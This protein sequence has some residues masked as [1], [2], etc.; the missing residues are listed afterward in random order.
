MPTPAPAPALL[1]VDWGTTAL[2]GAL[3]AADGRP[4]ASHAAPRGLLSVPPGGW[5][6]AFEAE[7]G[8]WRRA[9]P[10]LPC[11]MAGMVGSR[12]GWAEAAYCPCPAGLDDLARQLLWVLPGEVAIVPG[13]S[14]ESG[15]VPDV[16]RG[17][18]TQVFGAL[19]S[20]A[21]AGGDHCL[22]LPG[23]H[24]KWV[25]VQGGRIT[26]FST[27]MTG[28]CYAL[29]RQQSILARML[30]ADDGD[31]VAE[32]FDAGITQA[33][34]PGGVL[35]HLFSVRT[36]ALFNRADGA[37][38]A[39]RLS[40]LLI[41]EELRAQ[42]LA[43]GM[44]VTVLGSAALAPRYQRALAS[45]GHPV[46]LAAADATWQGLLAVARTAGL[47]PGTGAGTLPP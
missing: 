31:L 5:A 14:T 11:L 46:Q 25:Q 20:L 22:V 32:A 1:A 16:M 44:P 30:P 35:H 13:L 43:P 21:G 8:A 27:H 42:A 17:E 12:Q 37:A 34:Q 4:L 15:G 2:R 26:G 7:F 24:S 40:G 28:E 18:E 45:Q 38:L 41:G 47:L 9:H 29:L 39:S 33:Q 10:G 19:A 6:A 23:T 36:L 3:L